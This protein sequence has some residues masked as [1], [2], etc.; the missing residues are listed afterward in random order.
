MP[1][2]FGKGT[3]LLDPKNKDEKTKLCGF[4]ESLTLQPL[5]PVKYILCKQLTYDLYCP[6]IKD[7]DPSTFVPNVA[8]YEQ[9]KP[10]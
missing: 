10:Y 7:N 8:K 5:C 4:Y 1:L 6:S 9:Q 3:T 2:A